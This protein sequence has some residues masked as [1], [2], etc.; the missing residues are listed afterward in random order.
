MPKRKHNHDIRH[1]T[2]LLD[3]SNEFYFMQTDVEFPDKS[4]ADFEL[5]GCT[6]NGTSVKCVV[7]D[8]RPH[9][10]INVPSNAS[11]R[12]LINLIQHQFSKYYVTAEQ[13]E[14]TSLYHYNEVSTFI[15][16][17]APS[18]MVLYTIIKAIKN[19]LK[20]GNVSIYPELYE[21]N[22]EYILRAMVET[23][24]VGCTWHRLP[25]YAYTVV[26]V[27]PHEIR[28]GITVTI[29]AS[30]LQC[31]SDRA[32]IAPLRML[33]FD[34][35]CMGRPGFFPDPLVDSVI[36]IAVILYNVQAM[37]TPIQTIVFTL[38]TC[39]P[40]HNAEVR[41]SDTVDGLLSAFSQY[42]RD[43]DPDI[44]TGYNINDFDIPY[45]INQANARHVSMFTHLGRRLGEET[46]LTENTSNSKAHGK[47]VSWRANIS[48]RIVFDMLPALRKDYKL[49]SY[50]LNA[51]SAHF[52]GDQKDDIHYTAISGLQMGDRGTRRRL[53]R[54]CIKDAQLPCQLFYKLTYLSKTV[55]MAR[56]A[57]IPFRYTTQRGEQIKAISGLL[58]RAKE[59]GYV[60]PVYERE[61]GGSN[62]V[63]Y[64][65][66]TVIEPVR[67][68]Y[69]IPIATLD[70]ASLYPSII[71][72]H[73]LCY[74]TLLKTGPLPVG[75][76]DADVTTTPYGS[77]FVKPHV[78]KGLLPE[79][80]AA[81]L[82]ARKRT[83]TLMKTEKSPFMYSVLDGRQLALKLSANSVYGF[84]GAT[85]GMLPC[86]PI[87]ASVTA[88]GREMIEKTKKTVEETY[89]IANGYDADAEVIYGDTDSVMIKFGIVDDMPK[90]MT[91]AKAAAELATAQ[92][93]TPIKLEFEKVYFP[94][95]L[96]NKKRYAGLYWTNPEQ[97]DK[98]DV[99]GLVSVRRDNCRL[100]SNLVSQVLK[101]IVERRDLDGAVALVHE[102]IRKLL[103][104]NIDI[105]HLVITKQLK[106]NYTNRQ[107]H[108]E[109]AKKLTQRGN[110][111]NIGERIP[112]VIVQGARNAKVYEKSEDPTYVIKNKIPIDT[113]YYLKQQM[114]KPL[115][116]IFEPIYG[117][118]RAH[119]LLFVGSHMNTI[120]KTCSA[121]SGSIMKYVTRTVV[122]VGCNVAL[123]ATTDNVLRNLC[124]RCLAK[125]SEV[126]I[127][128]QAE[129]AEYELTASRLRSTCMRCQQ[130]SF[131]S[132]DSCQNQTCPIFFTRSANLD[133][134]EK[135]TRAMALAFAET[136]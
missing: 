71:M 53:A 61:P 55:E 6:D 63:E 110:A 32:D 38:N 3:N 129:V 37:E 127:R 107:P 72:A 5:Y 45:L 98:V 18:Q 112:Y 117:A 9:F 100:I 66:A 49:R 75:M 14:R 104:N 126:Y 135:R 58:R 99:K 77:R 111:P 131:G 60:I 113:A 17:K 123:T 21:T 115:M 62:G 116:G 10:Y 76:T 67:G 121:T 88:Y 108:S 48:G 125:E 89:T 46:V 7:T 28:T 2:P 19:G 59:N 27:P 16:I 136:W 120:V 29:P 82:G 122:C 128:M 52:L 44:I 36:Q 65:G 102:T 25:A 81:F 30:Q 105:G 130:T 93:I 101:Y 68:Y 4:R 20:D 84:T 22:I 134:Y 106:D 24:S 41:E 57:G 15:K 80:L 12:Q 13:V 83:K 118:S 11:P 64:E 31:D 74:T 51:V 109:L 124:H 39:A 85:V 90:V 70:F 42:V 50:T 43:T 119:A 35:E 54:Y 1:Q 97:W 92:F 132:D 103:T 73:N 33:G 40:I 26:Y 78:R 87:S 86:I 47:Q 79:M 96:I 23:N 114:E 94:Y 8:L 34:I 56:V 95:L 69:D 133:K 91:I